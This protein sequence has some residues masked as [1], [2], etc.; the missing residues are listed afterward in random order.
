PYIVYERANLSSPPFLWQSGKQPEKFLNP[1]AAA[2]S[3]EHLQ[4]FEDRK[5]HFVRTC[6]LRSKDLLGFFCGPLLLAPLLTLPWL[7]RDRRIHLL[8]AQLLLSFLGL[9]AV[10]YF[11]VHYAAPLT[12]TIFALAIQG[13]RH[14]RRWQCAGKSVGV[15]LT[16]AV[17]LIT[18]AMIP[19]H[20]AKTMHDARHSLSWTDPEMLERARIVSQL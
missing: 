17:V 4:E 3:Q 10:T 7:L 9:L 2:F 11:F 19:A 16:R 6:W 15:G 18:L 12:A 13:M 5:T 20:I 8:I 14:L 1:Q